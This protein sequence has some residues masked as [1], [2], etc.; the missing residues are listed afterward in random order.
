MWIAY[1]IS[2]L[3]N[4]PPTSKYLYQMAQEQLENK[5]KKKTKL[6]SAENTTPSLKIYNA[7]SSKFNSYPYKHIDF[8]FY[9][10]FTLYIII[11]LFLNIEKI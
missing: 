3:N 2:K 1:S 5:V 4:H 10:I 11:M 7:A 9:F 6:K 8:Y